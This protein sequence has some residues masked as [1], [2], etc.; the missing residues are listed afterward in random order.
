MVVGNKTYK[1]V[2]KPF[3]REQVEASN[4]VKPLE[5]LVSDSET[6]NIRRYSLLYSLLLEVYYNNFSYIAYLFFS[7]LC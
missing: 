2:S 6:L 5:V 3:A 4:L 1:F 7:A